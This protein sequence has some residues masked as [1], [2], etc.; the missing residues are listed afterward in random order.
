MAKKKTT[1]S[2]ARKPANRRATDVVHGTWSS[3]PVFVLA[4]T[5]A[6]IGLNSFWQFPYVT[7]HNGGT[8]F[9]LAFAAALLIFAVPLLMAEIVIGRRA[10]KL[11]AAAVRY[12]VAQDGVD[13]LWMW[14]GWIVPVTGF[15]VFLY[16]CVIGSWTWAYAMRAAVGAFD[17]KTLDGTLSMFFS[18]TS[19][20]EKQLF[21]HAAFVASTIAAVGRGVN[22][23]LEP[24]IRVGVPLLLGAIAMLALYGSVAGD[25]SQAVATLFQFSPELFDYKSIL[26]AVTEALFCTGVG[27]SAVMA[28]GS[29]LKPGI[30]IAASSFAVSALVLLASLLVSIFILSVLLA[31]GQQAMPGPTLLFQALPYALARLAGGELAGVLVYATLG[32]ASWLSAI[33]LIDAAVG[34]LRARTGLS[35]FQ[36]TLVVAL[37]GWFLGVVAILSFNYWAFSF[38]LLGVEKRLGVF[39][40]VQMVTSNVLI[41]IGAM[42]AALLASWGLN[43]IAIR[44]ELDLRW[45]IAFRVWLYVSRSVVPLG[46]LALVFFIFRLY[47]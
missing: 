14:L 26:I 24:A 2:R 28:Y 22:L 30:S 3:G 40:M 20:P 42:L 41:P 25:G 37:A 12:L 29:Y 45:P 16:L 8:V 9:L 38:R 21:W 4:V 47:R 33:A 6:A 15:L 18:F 34:W 43:T 10:G 1:A 36:A 7:V 19:D 27:V 44:K 13:P 11:P 32:L 17:G 23:G 39:D 31:T 35:H 46:M 5:G